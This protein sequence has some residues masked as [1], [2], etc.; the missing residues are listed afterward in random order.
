MNCVIVHDLSPSREVKPDEKAVEAIK[1]IFYQSAARTNL[2]KIFI[3]ECYA[4]FIKKERRDIY[5]DDA[6]DK[7]AL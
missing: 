4:V 1:F 6:A 3:F 7:R 5:G 2:H